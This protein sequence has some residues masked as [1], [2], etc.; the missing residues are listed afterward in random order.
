MRSALVDGSV[1]WHCREV[2]E[3]ATKEVYRRPKTAGMERKLVLV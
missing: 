1:A 2:L 3:E